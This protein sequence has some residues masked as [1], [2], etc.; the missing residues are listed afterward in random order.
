MRDALDILF[1]WETALVLGAWLTLAFVARQLTRGPREEPVAG[2]AWWAMRL[3]VRLMHRL[4]VEGREHVPARRGHGPIILVANHTSGVDPLLIQAVMPCE[5][6]FLMARDMQPTALQD[7]WDWIEAIPVSRE[8]ADARAAR[9]AIRWLRE[10]EVDGKGGVIGI[11]PEGGIER[12]RR[13]ILPFLPGI[14]LLVH[15]GKAPVLP[16][17]IDDTPYTTTAWGSLATRSR[18]SLRF[19]PPID[20]RESGL[21]AAQI[22][23]DLQ[24]RFLEATGW[25]PN[26]EPRRELTQA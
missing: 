22:A 26:D 15:R 6:R 4:R 1:S 14:G 18:A 21:G 23:Q 13:R 3:Y 19:L 9:E 5:V 12:P 7:L 25:P 2:L 17:V 24:R 16:V 8:G 20:Y 10:G 11:F